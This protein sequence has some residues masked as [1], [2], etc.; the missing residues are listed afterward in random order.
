M[1]LTVS[2]KGY[3]DAYDCGYVTFASFR[4]QLAEAFNEEFWRLYKK[5]CMFGLTQE[6]CDIANSITAGHDALNLFL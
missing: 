4:F 5:W 2:I 6:E 3:K 1:G